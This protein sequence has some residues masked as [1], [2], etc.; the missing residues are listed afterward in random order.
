M[1]STILLVD[2]HHEMLEVVG[3]ELAEK[4]NVVTALNGQQAF[5]LLPKHSIDLI[6]SDVMMPVMDGFELC[7]KIKADI[8]YGHIPVILLTAKT[9]LQSKIAGLELGADAYI[10]KPF[11]VEHLLVQIE[12]LFHNRRKLKEHFSKFSLL[13]SRIVGHPSQ[14]KLF[15]DQLNEAILENLDDQELNIDK[16]AR[17]TNM[18][19][20][21]LFRK[22]KFLLDCTPN[23]L[24]NVS[25]LKVAA[26]LLS[27][28]TYKIY[29]VSDRVGYTSQTHFGRNFYKQFGMTP[30]E[31]QKQK[32]LEKN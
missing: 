21:S 17:L 23:E 30:T 20:T 7:K 22:I 2:D 26:D 9:T 4:Y 15:L 28:G 12:N 6:V 8:K 31:Y 10:E 5:N 19:R 24:I 27:E 14:D 32:Q 29:E 25:R 1:K 3:E 16:L 18:S 13:P 11:E